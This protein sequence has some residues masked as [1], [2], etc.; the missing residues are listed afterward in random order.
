MQ[1]KF[2]ITVPV[3]IDYPKVMK[4]KGLLSRQLVETEESIKLDVKVYC[5]DKV[6]TRRKTLSPKHREVKY[7]VY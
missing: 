7:H 3:F 4:K 2:E 6:L 5:N 1:N